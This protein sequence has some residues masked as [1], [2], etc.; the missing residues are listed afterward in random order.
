MT[1]SATPDRHI[2]LSD[3]AGALAHHLFGTSLTTDNRDIVLQSGVLDALHLA[4][5]QE[6]NIIV[7][8]T[9]EQ[10]SKLTPIADKSCP[11]NI[12]P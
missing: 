11:Q 4:L 12:L 3:L 1:R 6:V 10:A 2:L 9:P 8:L 5:G 7:P